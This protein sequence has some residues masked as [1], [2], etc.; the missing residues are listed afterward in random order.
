MRS[1]CGRNTRIDYSKWFSL[2]RGETRG[3]GDVEKIN[4]V[5]EMKRKKMKWEMICTVEETQI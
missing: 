1:G 3:R 2:L 4:E 5:V